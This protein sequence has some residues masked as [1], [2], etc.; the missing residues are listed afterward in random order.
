MPA[1][2]RGEIFLFSFQAIPNMSKSVFISVGL[3]RA[4]TPSNLRVSALTVASQRG[5]G[6]CAS[7]LDIMNG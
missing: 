3:E 4:L 1:T 7:C 6:R 5:S 2:A